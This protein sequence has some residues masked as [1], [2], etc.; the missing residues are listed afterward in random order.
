MFRTLHY[1]STALLVGLALL[2]TRGS[3]PAAGQK[4][5]RIVNREPANKEPSP[6]TTL[7]ASDEPVISADWYEPNEEDFKPAYH[8]DPINLAKQSW[9]EY[10]GWVKSFYAGNFLDSGWTKRCKSVLGNIAS[11]KKRTQLRLKLNTIGRAIAAEWAKTREPRKIDT[12]MLINWGARLKEA[13]NK[14][15]GE[16]DAIQKEIELI[17]KEVGIGI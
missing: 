11:E 12:K 8:G 10:W 1:L 15:N 7:L 14:D 6:K 4:P 9:S 16:G 2:S 5:S 13:T 17:A 3:L